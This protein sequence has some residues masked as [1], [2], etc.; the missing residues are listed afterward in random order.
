MTAFPVSWRLLTGV[1]R[2]LLLDQLSARWATATT[3]CAGLYLALLLAARLT[4]YYADQFDYWTV[5]VVPVTGLLAALL[6]PA[7]PNVQAAA[8]RVDQQQST[9]DLF[10]TLTLL[11]AAPGDYKPL[12]GYE[13]ESRAQKIKPAEVVPFHWGNR[14]LNILGVLAVLLL[15]VW[16]IPT[17]DP[18]GQVAASQQEQTQRKQIEDLQKLNELRKEQLSRKDREREN[19]AEVESALERL[20]LALSE[21]KKGDRQANQ[22][23]LQEHQQELGKLFRD[24]LNS[25]EM[26]KLA[27]TDLR[28][29]QKFGSLGEQDLQRKMQQELQ[30]GK[31]ET[32][33]K[34]LQELTEK[35]SQLAETKD[36]VEKTQLEREVQKQLKELSDF[37]SKKAGSQSMQNALERAQQALDALRQA[38]SGELSQAAAEALQESLDLAKQEA[39]ALAQAARDMQS[40]EEALK[41]IGMAK[42]LNAEDQLEAQMNAEN[43]SLQDYQE[44]YAELMQLMGGQGMGEGDGEGEGDG[45]GGRGMGR[46]DVAQERDEAKTG[47]Q[48]ELSQSQLQQGRLLL[49]LKTKGLSESGEVTDEQYSAAVERIRQNLEEVIEQEQIPPGYVEGIKKYF[50]TLQKKRE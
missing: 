33:Q 14:V 29:D 16:L 18:F 32:L 20:K 26:K 17:L 36:P 12:V 6:W 43:M 42:R 30:Q 31:T 49:S 4:G 8:H 48:D 24:K 46:G 27:G 39:E 3:I 15:A 9:R 38:Q 22:D 28:A 37:A 50:D 25:A 11:D 19:S 41:A 35:L 21:M 34:Q 47:F 2:R 13:A 23:R 10:L 7:R 5:A 45:M 44:L 1:R 40:L